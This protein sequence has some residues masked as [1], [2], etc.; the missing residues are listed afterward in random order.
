MSELKVYPNYLIAYREQIR[1]GKIKAGYELTKELDNLIEDL[2]NPRYIYD[3]KDA[4]ERIDFIQNC[5]RLTKA[6]F[7]NKPMILML[8]QKAFIEVMY[9]FKM[10]DTGFDRFQKI[11]LLIAR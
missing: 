8:W 10:A 1:I 2:E 7:Y 5:I 6:P 3:T 9:S 4:Y 11:V